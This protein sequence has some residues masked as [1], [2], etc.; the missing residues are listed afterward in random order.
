[1]SVPSSTQALSRRAVIGYIVWLVCA[2]VA[3][4]MAQGANLGSRF[5]INAFLTNALPATTLMA[6]AWYVVNRFVLGHG[7]YSR[8]RIAIGVLLWLALTPFFYAFAMGGALLAA[9]HL[10]RVLP[11]AVCMALGG[12]VV[13][14][15]WHR[16]A[17]KQSRLRPALRLACAGALVVI[18]FFT[19]ML[20]FPL[21]SQF[22]TAWQ[23]AYCEWLLVPRIESY[24]AENGR[25]PGSLAEVISPYTPLPPDL[26]YYEGSLRLEDRGDVL[27]DYV[28]QA[29]GDWEYT[30]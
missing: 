19:Q 24:R 25:M 15:L 12:L 18:P 28:Y 9:I 26:T 29:P 16:F 10:L 30:E 14:A 1:M 7:G 5:A 13:W 27:A 22:A 23:M 17:R 11:Y 3:L 8:V 20:V 21:A 4:A 6:L 2:P